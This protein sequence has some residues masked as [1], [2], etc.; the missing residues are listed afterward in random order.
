LPTGS[1][2]E[3]GDEEPFYRV[4]HPRFTVLLVTLC[5]GGKTNAMPVSWV[6]PV[7]D[8][9]PLLAFSVAKTA[10]THECLE[11]SGE[12]TVNVPPPDKAELLCELGSRRGRETD[13]AAA[14]GLRLEPGKTVRAPFWADSLAYIECSIEKTL[15]AGPFTLYLARARRTV[16]RADLYSPEEGWLLS[17]T[18]PLLHGS[19]RS[20][21]LVGRRIL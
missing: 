6:T 5:P 20:F 2:K 3:L 8:N 21:Y 17:K 10:Y 9:P 1:F 13:K 4:L 18:S 12:A 14:Y 7:S 16:V 15:D 19:G 11:H